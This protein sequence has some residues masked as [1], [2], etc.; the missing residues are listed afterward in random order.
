MPYSEQRSSMWASI[1]STPLRVPRC[2]VL[3]EHGRQGS[4]RRGWVSPKPYLSH[5][6]GNTPA[7][8]ARPD[9]PDRGRHRGQ[10]PPDLGVDRAGPRGRRPA[11][12][13]ARALLS[14]YPPEDLCC[15][16]TSSTRC[17]RAST[18][19]PLRSKESSPSSAS[20]A[21]RAPGRGARAL[22]P[23]DRPAP[24]PG[25]QLARGPRRRRGPRECT[26]SAICRT[27]ASSTS[28]ATSSPAPSRR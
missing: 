7:P 3:P 10:C 18:R 17:G 12:H 27:T 11:R 1:S 21:G 23:A 13:A 2:L 19:S 15:A 25:L 4:P 28:A 24:S 22:R 6:R 14:G 16:V 26:G 5:G 20:R 8:G 9:R